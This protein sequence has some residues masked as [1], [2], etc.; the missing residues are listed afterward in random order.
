MS[1]LEY[2]GMQIFFAHWKRVSTNCT[3]RVVLGF[4]V[5]CTTTI[6]YVWYKRWL[7]LN[8]E[9]STG[10]R[11]GAGKKINIS[12]RFWLWIAIAGSMYAPTY[13]FAGEINKKSARVTKCSFGRLCLSLLIVHL[14]V[15]IWIYIHSVQEAC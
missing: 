2:P 9:T 11:K 15:H 13:H 1:F 6:A 4:Y 8:V 3:G 10:H 14:Y 7:Y 5:T 12:M